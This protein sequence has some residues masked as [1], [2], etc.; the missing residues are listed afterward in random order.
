MRRRLT[1]S[2]PYNEHVNAMETLHATATVFAL[3]QLRLIRIVCIVLVFLHLYLSECASPCLS[4]RRSVCPS[5]SAGVRGYTPMVGCKSPRHTC[6]ISEVSAALQ[7]DKRNHHD[8]NGDVLPTNNLR[9]SL[10]VC[11]LQNRDLGNEVP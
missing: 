10:D 7:R 1:Y 9:I 3:S 6:R 5:P 11:S 4:V 8:D 2:S